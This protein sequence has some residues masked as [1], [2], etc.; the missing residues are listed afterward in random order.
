MN[1]VKPK[2]N[3]QKNLENNFVFFEPKK[4]VEKI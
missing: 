3:K 1:T 4:F 2:T